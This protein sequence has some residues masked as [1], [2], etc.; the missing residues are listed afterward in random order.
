MIFARAL[1]YLFAAAVVILAANYGIPKSLG[2]HPFWSTKI[3][4]IGVPVGLVLAVLIR[5]V[6]WPRR[7]GICLI[8]LFLAAVAAHQGRLV[9]AASFAEN[10]LAGLF[11]FYGWIA[12]AAATTALI[13]ALLTP[14][15][16][17]G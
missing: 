4:L 12:V 15:P 6:S 16:F 1:S 8:A 5:K 13:A 17:F 7:L 3:A 10:H 9:F 2:A 11:W 14:R